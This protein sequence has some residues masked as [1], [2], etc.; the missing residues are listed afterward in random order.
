VTWILDLDGV[1]WLGDQPIPG[2]SEAI[3]RLR[4]ADEDVIFLTNNSS[5]TVGQYRAKLVSMGVPAAPT[6]VV[7]SAQ[8]AATLLEPGST[9]L[10]CGGD[11]V[12]EALE[13]RGVKMVTEGDVD[14]VVV[15]WHRDFDFDRLAAATRALRAGARLVATNDDPT[16]P[17]PDGPLPGAGAILAAVATAGGV[18]PTVAGK[19]YDAMVAVLADRT[20]GPVV[21]I[22][23]RPSTD[24]RLA[25]RLEARFGLV[26]SG[27][28]AVSDLPV[29]PVPD[30]IGADLA[31]VVSE[32]LGGR[33]AID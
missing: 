23:D 1:V 22:G 26:L 19:P 14:A 21:V 20:A 7:T 28:T 15:G 32:M 12:R 4:A 18:A 30:V 31:M 24:G 8:A 3:A 29:E 25:Q 10:V 16:Y 33:S 5:L 6:D 2:S 27:I 13:E 9:T 17:S 11:G